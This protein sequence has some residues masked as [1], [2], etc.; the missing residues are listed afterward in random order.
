MSRMYVVYFGDDEPKFFPD[1]GDGAGKAAALAAAD[2]AVKELWDPNTLQYGDDVDK[3]F[4]AE[5]IAMA[6]EDERTDRP[7]P[8][9]LDDE[10]FDNETGIDWSGG[11][12][13]I[14]DYRV[15]VLPIHDTANVSNA[16]T[17]H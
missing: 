5:I 17:V 3:I 14:C 10:G 12:E 6:M 9:K 13:Y 2:Q 15:K 16:R 4:V 11:L 7:P 8:E 1:T